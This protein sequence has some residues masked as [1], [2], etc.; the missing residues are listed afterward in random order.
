MGLAHF[1]GCRM[2]R[3]GKRPIL[4]ASALM[5]RICDLQV[6]G[7]GQVQ[8]WVNSRDHCDPH[9]HCADKSRTWE[10]RVK[11]SFVNNT[12]EF[13]DIWSSND[14]GDAIRSE[15]VTQL[16]SL[17]RRCREE[18]WRNFSSTIGCCLKNTRQPDIRNQMWAV[19]DAHYDPGT[20]STELTFTNGFRRTVS[21]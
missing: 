5:G 18:W 12:V 2:S 1:L 20:N 11:F 10:G 4:V 8:V 17:V 9:V 14:P 7:A 6:R 13:W 19:A 21:L 3:R 16:T 15:I